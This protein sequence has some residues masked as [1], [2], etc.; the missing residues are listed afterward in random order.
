MKSRLRFIVL[1]TLTIV[2]LLGTGA[3]WAHPGPSHIH[4]GPVLMQDHSAHSPF[5]Q[6]SQH[7]QT[8]NEGQSLH[9]ILNGHT[10]GQPCPH[11]P[12]SKTDNSNTVRISSECGGH[13]GPGGTALVKTGGTYN[14]V[15]P[16]QNELSCSHQELFPAIHPLL[17]RSHTET[18]P[19][20]KRTLL[21]N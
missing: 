6:P 9:C 12:A 4:E 18:A 14:A 13:T 11:M 5:H 8:K 3:A 10:K 2:M 20:P 16:I 7:L 17:S 21:S 1:T 15:I 19:P